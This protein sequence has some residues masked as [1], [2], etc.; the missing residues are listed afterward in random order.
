M[1]AGRLCLC[2]FLQISAL[3]DSNLSLVID[4]K[5]GGATT[6][7]S[8]GWS[9]FKQCCPTKV[10]VFLPSNLSL[11]FSLTAK[12]DLKEE[13]LREMT[14]W[15]LW[16]TLTENTR[17]HVSMDCSIQEVDQNHLSSLPKHFSFWSNEELQVQI[18]FKTKKKDYCKAVHL[19]F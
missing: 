18:K 14:P 16:W 8:S 12:V 1:E 6:I 17:L 3:C 7:L 13:R 10:S 9:G 11:T 2:G 19:F 15:S 5:V 4:R